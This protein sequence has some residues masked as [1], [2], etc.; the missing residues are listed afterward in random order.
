VIYKSVMVSRFVEVYTIGAQKYQR[1]SEFSNLV[2]VRFKTQLRFTSNPLEVSIVDS[3]APGFISVKLTSET[4]YDPVSGNVLVSFLTKAAWPYMLDPDNSE[5]VSAVPSISGLT[6]DIANVFYHGIG[7][8]DIAQ[9]TECIQQWYARINVGEN[10]DISGIYTLSSNLFCRDVNSTEQGTACP[11]SETPAQYSIRVKETDLC[12]P[13]AVSATS[14][15]TL[16]LTPYSDQNLLKTTDKYQTGDSVYWKVEV[17]NP[18][19]TIDT[20]EFERISIGPNTDDESSVDI[21]YDA[22][23]ITSS[24]SSSGLSV[25]NLEQKVAP[26][27]KAELYFNYYLIRSALPNTIGLL[28]G[29][30]VAMELRTTVVLNFWFHGNQ[31]RATMELPSYTVAQYHT[32][33]VVN[34]EGEGDREGNAEESTLQ[35]TAENNMSAGVPNVIIGTT[36][37]LFVFFFVFVQIFNLFL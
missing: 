32:V 8:C 30:G 20:I 15:L 24:G 28:T 3:T 21:L 22:S 16:S 27:Q 37:L 31:K 6:V 18:Q 36:P 1:I 23:A 33:Q 4:V 2:T 5:F 34:V 29:G 35:K 11:E 25:T 10:C 14:Q 19:A 26:G 9:N 12:A 13:E 7:K 17:V